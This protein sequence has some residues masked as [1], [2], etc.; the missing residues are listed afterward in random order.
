[1]HPELETRHTTLLGYL[2]AVLEG[3]VLG[4]V[5]RRPTET[6]TRSLRPSWA[7]TDTI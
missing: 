2:Q 7:L 6:P 5:P 1:M 4:L 3:R